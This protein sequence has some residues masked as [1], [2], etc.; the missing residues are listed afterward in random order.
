MEEKDVLDYN[1]YKKALESFK[2]ELQDHDERINRIAEAYRIINPSKGRRITTRINKKHERIL[3]EIA[4]LEEDI[5]LL[6]V[7]D[8]DSNKSIEELEQ[9]KSEKK[10]KYIKASKTREIYVGDQVEITKASEKGI[11]GTVHKT[12]P[13]YVWL[14]TPRGSIIQRHRENVKKLK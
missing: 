7:D 12:S 11:R 9:I 6:K 10:R 13:C 4:E 2:T 3:R 8:E 1:Q 5:Q 14:E